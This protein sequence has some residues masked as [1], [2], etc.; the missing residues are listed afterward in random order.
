MKIIFYSLL[1]ILLTTMVYPQCLPGVTYDI[2]YTGI[3]TGYDFQSGGSPQQICKNELIPSFL[4]AVIMKSD[5][6]ANWTDRKVI[7]LFSPDNGLS[8]QNKGD[9]QTG[10]VVTSGY[11][12]ISS[13]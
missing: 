7:Y 8:W 1:A 12:A 3:L 2:V 10:I 4:H 11:P 5:Q 6:P 13:F 9:V